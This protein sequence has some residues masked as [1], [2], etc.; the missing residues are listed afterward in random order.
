MPSFT[1]LSVGDN[2]SLNRMNPIMIGLSAP[3]PKAWYRLP[4]PMNTLNSANTQNKC[5][6]LIPSSLVVWPISQ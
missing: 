1:R 4:F 2:T 6:L 5:A 3:N